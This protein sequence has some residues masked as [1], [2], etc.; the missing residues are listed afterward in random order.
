[1]NMRE[2]THTT[3]KMAKNDIEAWCHLLFPSSHII[4]LRLLSPK[5]VVHHLPKMG[6]NSL[7]INDGEKV[8]S[9]WQSNRAC[10]YFQLMKNTLKDTA[11]TFAALR[12][13]L[14]LLAH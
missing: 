10:M 11:D 2:L 8:G 5:G 3:S 7:N 12:N 13:G 6:L 1:M 9:I 4:P 14:H